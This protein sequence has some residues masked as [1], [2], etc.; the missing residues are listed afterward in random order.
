MTDTVAPPPAARSVISSYYALAG[1]YTLAASVIWG[2][3][4]LFLLDAGLSFF[5]VFLAN[6]AYSVGT[7]LFE[8]PTGVVADTLGRRASFLFSVIVLAATTLLYVA[9]AET[10]AGVA[11]FAVVSVFMGLG[12]TF[13][14]GA[15]EAWLVDALAETDYEGQLD[16]VFARGQQVVGG[17]MLIG[18]VAGGLLGQ[19]SLSVPFV[20]RSLLL[21]ILFV[22]AYGRMRD[23]G[24]SPRAMTM[25]ELPAEMAANARAGVAF[26]WRQR[27]LRLLMVASMVQMGF[28]GWAFYAW[29]PYLLDLLDRD[30][31][32]V[33]GLVSA[34]ISLSAIAGNQVVEWASERCGRRTT[35]MLWA[36]GLQ[37]SAAVVVGLATSF[38]VALP[39]LLLMTSALGLN[40][41]VR[42]AYVHSVVPSS[43]R[44][45]VVSFDSMI[46]G[47]GGVGGQ[48][49]LGALGESRSVSA[50]YVVGGAVT[51][52]ALPVLWAVRRLGGEADRI[53]G[54]AGGVDGSCAAPG[55]PAIATVQGQHAQTV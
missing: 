17:A 1:L 3:N 36:A 21:A 50:G 39:A 30:A 22:L 25:G 10:G 40:G 34:G 8:I 48:V 2:V 9:L 43:Q 7:V 46:S 55:L 15:V 44:A 29:Q 23:I 18:T 6:A 37:T 20:V 5:E 42:Q 4:T 45:T 49:G 52:V 24:F 35:L 12:F 41:P 51:V 38:W 27:P 33:A 14:S 19:W 16:P 31:I 53:V 26:G 54:A 32:W 11:V 28:L 13:Y 47:A